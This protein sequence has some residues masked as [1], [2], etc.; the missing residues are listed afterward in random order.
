MLIPLRIRRAIGIGLGGLAFVYLAYVLGIHVALHRGALAALTRDSRDF[1]LESRGGYSFWPGRIVLEDARFRF[2]DYNIEVAIEARQISVS[3]SPWAL[4]AKTIQIDEF[5]AHDARY[6]M[7]H[8][9]KHARRNSE[10]LAAFPDIG[11]ERSKVYDAPK[12]P[13]GIPPFKIRVDSIRANVLEVWILEFRALGNFEATGS[14]EL[15]EN[16][17]V[18]PSHADLRGAQVFVGQKKL[19]S[20]FDCD[21]RANVGPFPGRDPIEKALE[22]TD[23]KIVCDAD[24]DDLSVLRMYWPDSE[25]LL[26]G[27]ARV[28][29]DL[30]IAR[31]QARA[32]S[33]HVDAGIR[34]LGFEHAFLAGHA[35]LG[36]EV[37]TTGLV[38]L[39]GQ[40]EGEGAGESLLELD[41]ARLELEAEQAKLWQPKLRNASIQ[42]A[43][44]DVRDPAFLRRL[45]GQ[46]PLLKLERANLTVAY[47]APAPEQL[48]TV[49][50]QSEGAVALF[51][52]ADGSISCAYRALLRCSLEERRAR[53]GD[54]TLECAPLTISAA[55]D[56]TGDIGARF[57]AQVLDLTPE[58]VAS[59]WLVSLG[60]P[61]DVLRATLAKSAWTD[62]GL[63]LAPLGT[64]EGRVRVNRHQRTIAATIDSAQSGQFSAEASLLFAETMVSEWRV[65][66]PLGRFGVSQTPTGTT[67]TPFV[68]SDWGTR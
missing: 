68:A 56:R 12:P 67:V 27:T 52:K 61:K 25:V 17:T 10:R 23:A 4:F 40:F 34:R 45:A 9:V 58:R 22:V 51:H 15:H 19:S 16:V 39:T 33:A 21:V 65:D 18:F 32:S 1:K 14:F 8:R 26:E 36:A 59:E 31:G 60:N 5:V 24:I 55:P 42:L 48:G 54:S 20:R 43:S 44:L 57:H 64:V 30:G 49:K 41:A 50:L 66:T 13:Y 47:A 2:K 29:T 53:C 6:K 3:W 11:F 7:L 62:L 35:R 28:R 63:A 38:R 46:A 37:A